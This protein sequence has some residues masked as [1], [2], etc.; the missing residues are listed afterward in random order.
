MVR[1]I[2]KQKKEEVRMSLPNENEIEYKKYKDQIRLENIKKEE[3]YYKLVNIK[4]LGKS[5]KKI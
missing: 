3:K 5:F 2:L 1:Q 4:L